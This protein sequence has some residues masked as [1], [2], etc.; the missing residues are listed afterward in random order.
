MYC[1]CVYDSCVCIHYVV[2]CVLCFMWEVLNCHSR[3]RYSFNSHV[4]PLSLSP[5]HTY[6]VSLCCPHTHTLTKLTLSPLSAGKIVPLQRHLSQQHAQFL[7]LR[8]N[9]LQGGGGVA[10]L[11]TTTPTNL[12]RLQTPPQSVL[13]AAQKMALPAG[14]EQLRP[15]VAPLPLQQ[16]FSAAVT[17][18][19]NAMRNIT[20]RSLQ[21]EEVLALLKQQSL[22]MA[23][24][25]TYRPQLQ[26]QRDGGSTAAQLQQQLAATV[27]PELAK[28]A[29]I[30][31]TEPS[32]SLTTEQGKKLPSQQQQQHGRV[33]HVPIT[34]AISVPAATPSTQVSMVTNPPAMST[35]AS[36]APSLTPPTTTQTTDSSSAPTTTQQSSK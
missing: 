11:T 26:Q 15:S 28:P 21:T 1:V 19:A 25:Q 36:H 9:T 30:L 18:A 29:V 17:S 5:T 6:Y 32:F 3:Y 34:T 27:R 22:R 24:N 12:P 16:R 23:A 2:R 14:I 31:T 33:V 35:P 8:Q 4:R 10:Q 20:S 7:L 13:G